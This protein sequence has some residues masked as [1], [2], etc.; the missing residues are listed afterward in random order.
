MTLI[1]ELEVTARVALTE[2]VSEPL[3]PVSVKVKL[4]V[5][6][7]AMVVMVSVELPEVIDVGE[8]EGDA[9]TG[10]PVAVKPTVPAK[11]FNGATVT[12]YVAVPPEMMEFVEGA[13]LTVKSGAVTLRVTVVLCA[14][15][16][17]VVPVIAKTEPPPGVFV[18][19]V[20]VR[21]EL[22]D[23]V[24]VLGEKEADAPAGRPGAVK[25]T[26]SVKPYSAPTVTVYVALPPGSTEKELGVADMEK[27]GPDTIKVTD[28]EFVSEP[29]V[30]VT[31]T[32]E[33]PVGVPDAVV[34]VIVELPDVVMEAGEKEAV[35]PDGKPVALRVTGPVNPLTAPIFTV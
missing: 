9:P 23:V 25:L 11:P 7:L 32:V 35:A 34:T 16:S 6:V 10:K 20:T 27:S 1:E 33:L 3:V 30:P 29:A 14:D 24:M 18:P 26:W 12:V 2:W 13:T 8:K 17:V 15:C 19:V 28:A 31:V 21:V 4:P 5:A 22:P